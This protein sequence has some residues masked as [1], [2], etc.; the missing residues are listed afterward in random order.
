MLPIPKAYWEKLSGTSRQRILY[1]AIILVILSATFWVCSL[2]YSS[3]T[4]TMKQ[5][6]IQGYNSGVLEQQK[7]YEDAIKEAQKQWAKELEEANRKAQEYYEL[8]K[9]SLNDSTVRIAQAEQKLT[10]TDDANRNCIP[11]W[12]VLEYNKAFGKAD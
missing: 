11:D 10:E 7:H 4:H 8:S 9:E 1:G 3:Y 2:M 6:Y 12:S 5:Q